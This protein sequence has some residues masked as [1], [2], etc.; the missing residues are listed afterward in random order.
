MG[1]QEFSTELTEM[2][3]G[4]MSTDM[5]AMV[6]RFYEMLMSMEVNNKLKATKSER[7]EKRT[8]YRSGYRKRRWD[9]QLGTMNLKVPKVREGGY[10]PSFVDPYKRIDK[11]VVQLVQEAYIKGVSTRKIDAVVKALGIEGISAGQVSVLTNELNDMVEE[12][13]NRLLD[14][15]KY[16]VLWIDALYEKVRVGGTY[17]NMAVIVVCAVNSEGQREVIAIEPMM[18]ESEASYTEVFRKL[19]ERGLS[20]VKL[21][22]S[23]AHSGL[24]AAIRKEFVGCAWQRCKVHFM[25]NILAHVPQKSKDA[26]AADLKEIWTALNEEEARKRAAAVMEKYRGRYPKAIQRLEAGLDDS[27]TFYSFPELD[28][29]KISSTNMIERLNKEIRRRTR[30]S[31]V[32]TSEQAY[33]K[34]VALYPMEYSDRWSRGRQRYFTQEAIESLLGTD[35]E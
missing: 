19:K 27:L 34:Q 16:P 9:T 33:V 25:R 22:I 30:V 3:M 15:L 13:R 5:K 1:E 17:V 28:A 11:A 18:E 4:L 23:D 6:Q 29:K 7:T 8:G 12:F 32:F 10:I 21:V 35:T 31:G 26:F 2:L 20:G 14:A 24:V